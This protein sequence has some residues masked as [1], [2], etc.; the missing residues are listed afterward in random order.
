MSELGSL[1]GSKSDPSAGS[2]LVTFR[3]FL[4]TFLKACLNSGTFLGPFFGPTGEPDFGFG[5]VQK[6][7]R[8]FEKMC[9][10]FSKKWLIR[11][12]LGTKN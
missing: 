8:F 2:F 4:Y 10:F 1:S 11:R 9:I 12:A 3:G 7:T 5:C 6:K